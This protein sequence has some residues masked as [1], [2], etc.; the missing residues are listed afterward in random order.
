MINLQITTAFVSISASL[1]AGLID[2][3][4]AIT[5]PSGSTEPYVHTINGV[6]YSQRVDGATL[7]VAMIEAGP[8]CVKR[9][10]VTGNATAAGNILRASPGIW[11]Y[12]GDYPGDPLF[13]QK[14]NGVNIKGGTGLSYTIGLAD[15]QQNFTIQET[16]GGVTVESEPV[17]LDF[18]NIRIADP[19][20]LGA[21][22]RHWFDFSDPSQI[23]TTDAQTTA[24]TTTGSI[25]RSLPDKKTGSTNDL[26]ANN[27]N[28]TWN[29]EKQQV[30]IAF[31][32]TDHRFDTR[33]NMTGLTATSEAYFTVKTDQGPFGILLRNG[34]AS[35]F[36]AASLSGSSISDTSIGSPSYTTD[37]VPLEG[38][39]RD[40]AYKEWGTGEG[41]VVG[42]QNLNLTPMNG[43]I[44][45]IFH[46]RLEQA[47]RMS[48]T[49]AVLTDGLT[50]S[51][52]AAL[53]AWLLE[54]VPT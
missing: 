52:R 1:G 53:V 49:H 38:T 54:R 36:Y 34:V 12:A 24:V 30:D 14:K 3:I 35:A 4:P 51:E 17:L 50:I 20:G 2:G 6:P 37:G 42:G 7:T 26:D 21:K 44:L 10:V 22:L 19:N 41:V 9:P 15:G 18:A 28:A 25:A 23:F 8:V 48:V 13:Q 5:A 29:A 27:N 11:V 32:T 39:R 43:G 47:C 33:Q 40:H 45:F 46:A 16:F 31:V